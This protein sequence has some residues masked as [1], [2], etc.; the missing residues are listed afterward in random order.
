MKNYL[1]Y[2]TEE[3]APKRRLLFSLEACPYCDRAEKALDEAGIEYERIQTP[4][5]DRSVIKLLSGQPTVPV[6]VEVIGCNEQDDDI[7]E[8]IE[9]L[10]KSK[11]INS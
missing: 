7:I 11:K 10:K 1:K 2:M 8:Y 5:A 9:E 6:L 3:K 4:V